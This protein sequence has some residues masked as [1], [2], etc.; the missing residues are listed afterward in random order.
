MLPGSDGRVERVGADVLE[1]GAGLLGQERRGGPRRPRRCSRRTAA[2][3][4]PARRR[5]RWPWTGLPRSRGLLNDPAARGAACARRPRAARRHAG[6]PRGRRRRCRRPRAGRTARR[7]PRRRPARAGPRSTPRRA[8]RPGAAAT[9]VSAAP[10]GERSTGAPKRP[11]ASVCAARTRSPV[12]ATTALPWPVSARSSTP[13]RRSGR[14]PLEQLG[15]A[16]ARGARG[17]HR[18][19]VEGRAGVAA[20]AWRSCAAHAT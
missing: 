15:A 8:R 18:R 2:G 19:L 6:T 5:V 13:A 17:A 14:E 9:S 10:A 20:L 1:R 7:A 3:R 16:E 12:Q 4:R 11:L